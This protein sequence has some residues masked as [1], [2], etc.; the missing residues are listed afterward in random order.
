ME[1]SIL[2]E[3]KEIECVCAYQHTKLQLR[4][5]IVPWKLSR[6]VNG[7]WEKKKK[8]DYRKEHEEEFDV[9]FAWWQSNFGSKLINGD[10]I[11]SGTC[12]NILLDRG[13]MRPTLLLY[14]WAIQSHILQ[15]YLLPDM[16][17]CQLHLALHY[18]EIQPRPIFFLLATPTSPIFCHNLTKM[19]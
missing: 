9:F 3:T 2:W 4:L 8:Q 18:A 16:Y 10:A 11:I 5:N 1:L 6:T 12:P 13:N 14:K 17:L 15:H 7:S 19:F